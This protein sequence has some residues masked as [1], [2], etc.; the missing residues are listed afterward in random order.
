MAI[1]REYVRI[2]ANFPK[3]HSKPSIFQETVI[4][5]PEMV[6]Q[7]PKSQP[8]KKNDSYKSFEWH[9][10]EYLVKEIQWLSIHMIYFIHY[11][12]KVYKNNQMKDDL[13][14]CWKWNG[15]CCWRFRLWPLCHLQLL[16]CWRLNCTMM[17]LLFCRQCWLVRF[18]WRTEFLDMDHSMLLALLSK[19]IGT[20]HL[21]LPNLFFHQILQ[22]WF[23][24]DCKSLFFLLGLRNLGLQ[25]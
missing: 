4:R 16:I 5:G 9:V 20:F 23:L 21:F 19:S 3:I 14:W 12:T 11:E 24:S 17:D 2:Q 1:N 15:W 25:F 10:F 7:T 13:T 8:K 22:G 18:Q 6:V